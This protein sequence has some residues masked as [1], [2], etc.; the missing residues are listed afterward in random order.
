MRNQ[1]KIDYIVDIVAEVATGPL[2]TVVYEGTYAPL[3]FQGLSKSGS[4]K[5]LI[6]KINS[7][8]LSN[9]VDWETLRYLDHPN[10][11]SYTF[12]SQKSRL[13]SSQ[14]YIVQDYCQN[15]LQQLGSLFQSNWLSSGVVKNAVKE[16]AAGLTYLH[17]KSIVHRNLKP[18]NILIKPPLDNP[19]R[20]II[21]DFWYTNVRAVPKNN[22]ACCC[23]KTQVPDNTEIVQWMAPE[24]LNDDSKTTS[25][26]MD[27]YSFGRIL[28]YLF[29]QGPLPLCKV[30][31]FLFRLLIQETVRL[32]PSSRI[33]SRAVL[34]KHPLVIV[35]AHK[36]VT[37]TADIRIDYI[38]EGYD[39]II[40]L[41]GNESDRVDMIQLMES[42]I[43]SITVNGSL[44]FP[45][46]GSDEHGSFSHRMYTE[47]NKHTK[48]PYNDNS[49]LD[50]LRMVRNFRKHPLTGEDNLDLLDEIE[51]DAISKNFPYIIPFL[52]ICL[53]CS[54]DS[55]F[56]P[57]PIFNRS[58]CAEEIEKRCMAGSQVAGP[59]SAELERE[60]SGVFLMA[61]SRGGGGPSLRRRG[62][63]RRHKKHHP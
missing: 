25:P 52:Y 11:A 15:T 35:P 56:V 28:E 47:M 59:V 26:M 38:R 14:T 19:S 5:V 24:L 23:F 27:M 16:I 43:R 1:I 18:S 53:D 7:R 36:N 58:I 46:S 37:V 31:S 9:K 2:M 4:K 3:Q 50:L 17:G 55:A 44:I 48:R 60:D 13:F 30:D 29:C 6:K 12:I 20:F 21:T 32:T 10:V 22:S 57:S 8:I 51:D 61:S 39:R 33:T 62:G 42:K 41:I 49:F 34:E 54:L 45:W 63:G 40:K